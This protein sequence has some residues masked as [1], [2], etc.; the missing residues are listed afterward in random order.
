MLQVFLSVSVLAF[1]GFYCCANFAAVLIVE[2]V[3]D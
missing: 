3:I 2:F 1:D